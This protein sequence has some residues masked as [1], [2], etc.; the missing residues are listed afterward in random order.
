VNPATANDRVKI[1]LIFGVFMALSL[2]YKVAYGRVY[3]AA[4]AGG[5]AAAGAP[6]WPGA[7]G[8]GVS[9]SGSA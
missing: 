7:G 9:A 4:G 8:F 2:R 6:G 5:V 3:L 1:R